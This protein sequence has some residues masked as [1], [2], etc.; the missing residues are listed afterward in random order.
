M[1]QLRITPS[2]SSPSTDLYIGRGLLKSPL[3]K[4]SCSHL[5]GKLVIVAEPLVRNLYAQELAKNLNAALVSIPNGE[6]AKSL[7]TQQY[8]LDELFKMG[9]DRDTTLIALGGGVTTDL[10]GFAASVY[11]RGIALI[12]IPTTLLG[13]VDAAI[14]G[15]TAINTAFGKNLLGTIYP[16]KAIFAD[17]DT[18]QT[19]HEKEWFNGLAEILKMGLIRDPSIWESAQKNKKDPDL[20]LKAIQ[21]KIQI[22]EQDPLELSLRRILNFGHTVGHALEAVSGYEMPHGQAVALGCCAEGYLS[23]QLGHLL[24]REF[25]KILEMYEDFQ[26]TLPPSYTRAGFL[27]A[28]SHDKKNSSGNIRFVLIDKIGHAMTFDGIYCRSVSPDQ[29]QSTLDWMEARYS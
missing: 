26:L 10:V 14:G 21:G 28:L 22:V 5:S 7:Q 8:L 17:L 25:E 1:H 9:A 18:L 12:F 3:L 16:P 6:A 20:I 4:N 24:P 13:M 15:K 11:L 27:Q 29:L 19:L 2:L 23:V